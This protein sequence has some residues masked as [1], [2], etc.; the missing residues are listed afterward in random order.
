MWLEAILSREDLAEV[1]EQLVPLKIRLDSTGKTGDDDGEDDR[2]LVL[3]DPSEVTLVADVGLRL[4]CKAS[5]RWPVLRIRVP[6]SVNALTVILRPHVEKQDGHDALVFR[7]EIA[8]A[9]LAGLP[10][11]VDA[12]ITEKINE[13][14]AEKSI[15]WD[16]TKTLSHSFPLPPALHGLAAFEL[17]V[18]GGKV[19]VTEDALGL[20]IS[21]RP[22]VARANSQTPT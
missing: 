20:A 3:H 4:V 2:Y 6:V 11:M 9:D 17:T 5:V 10:D 16:F 13:A 22:R 14:L 18:V 12:H 8:H 21:F 19:K 15:A 7:I 1:V